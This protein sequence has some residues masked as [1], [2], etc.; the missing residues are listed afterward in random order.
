MHPHHR[1]RDKPIRTYGSKRHTAPTPD[2]TRSSD[3]EPPAKKRKSTHEDLKE[4]TSEDAGGRTSEPASV[5]AESTTSAGQRKADTATTK[6]A[7]GSIL[8]YFQR[9][10][11]P[12]T[13]TSLSV[14]SDLC[15][16]PSSPPSSPPPIA[17]RRRKQPR[18]L[19]IRPTTLP[20][21]ETYGH[22][23]EE[24]HGGSEKE[25]A[26]QNTESK[27][28]PRSTGQAK[29]VL[30]SDTNK[31]IDTTLENTND[32]PKQR[33]KSKHSPSFQTT[34]NLSSRPAFSE[35]KVC[36]TVWNPLYPDDVRYH[37][38]RH[39]AVIRRDRQEKEKEVDLA[40]AP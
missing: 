33:P 2:T 25:N 8:N 12:E 19:R 35:C 27:D 15:P 5:K 29:R 22:D 18:L 4:T 20:E 37:S 17:N 13:A 32:L 14:Q 39:A 23:G 24:G 26:V 1:K 16:E 36:N 40:E 11:P 3:C 31:N 28:A 7:K 9:Q 6:L 21:I 38:K 30:L 10:P 34:L